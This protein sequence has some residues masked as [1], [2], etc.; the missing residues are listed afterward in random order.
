[1]EV[2]QIH[3]YDLNIRS[4]WNLTFKRIWLLVLSAIT[5]YAMNLALK[6]NNKIFYWYYSNLAI[7]YINRLI[8][9]FQWY[10]NRHHL[11]LNWV[12]FAPHFHSITYLSFII[13]YPVPFSCNHLFRYP[14]VAA[15]FGTTV[16]LP[17]HLPRNT[18]LI[19]PF[20]LR[21]CPIVFAWKL[22][23]TVVNIFK[24]RCKP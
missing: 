9:L 22:F 4:T 15:S 7:K 21:T 19:S 3:P 12:N 1:M 5:N 11:V 2:I 24:V 23:S 13:S 16:L 18:S 6:S 10:C 8:L 17:C 20:L 14:Q